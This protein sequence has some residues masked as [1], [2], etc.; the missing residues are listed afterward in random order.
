[1]KAT[2]EFVRTGTQ[3]VD[4]EIEIGEQP[5]VAAD[6]DRGNARHAGITGNGTLAGLVACAAAIRAHTEGMQ[7]GERLWAVAGDETRVA[8]YRRLLRYGFAQASEFGF[9]HDGSQWRGEG[10]I[11]VFQR[12]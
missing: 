8:A 1:M 5:F 4:V 2:V 7:I 12:E 9:N 6:W 10:R 3:D 11:F